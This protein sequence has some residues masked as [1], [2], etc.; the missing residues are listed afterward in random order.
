MLDSLPAELVLMIMRS[1]AETFVGSHRGTVISL[2]QTARFT[3]AAVKPIL[4][5]RLVVTYCN[6]HTIKAF[7]NNTTL[8]VHVRELLIN[9][10]DWTPSAAVLANFRNL[11]SLSGIHSRVQHVLDRLA[12]DA[13]PSLQT[14]HIWNTT[15]LHN[16][17]ASVTHVCLYLQHFDDR[18]PLR[19][20]VDWLTT[21]PSVTHI[22]LEVVPHSEHPLAVTDAS[23]ERDG[24]RATFARRLARELCALLDVAGPRLSQ[25]NVR[26]GGWMATDEGWV[27]AVRV[28]RR[29]AASN[30]SINQ[31][32]HLW[33]DH[34]HINNL[35]Q[36]ANAS[37]DDAFA[38][39]TVWDQGRTLLE[40]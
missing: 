20:L 33:R 4:Y 39:V 22:G 17:P 24:P 6:K 5:R 36:D 7:M 21:T 40:C 12:P 38:G 16:L 19:S 26:M 13:R 28:L 23:P 15:L 31:K 35:N 37:L 14:V 2:A 10:F 8:A 11:R 1:A 9:R 18:P 34:R 32:L 3:Y 29:A 25:L 30:N 27:P